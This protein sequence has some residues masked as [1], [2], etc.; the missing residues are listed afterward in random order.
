[1]S[2]GEQGDWFVDADGQWTWRQPDGSCWRQGGDGAWHQLA[3]EGAAPEP[4]APVQEGASSDP[5]PTVGLPGAPL[6]GQGPTVGVPGAP[7]GGQ[8]PTVGLPGAPL[9]GQGPTVGVPGSLLGVPHFGFQQIGAANPPAPDPGGDALASCAPVLPDQA[10]SP[11]HPGPPPVE[12]GETAAH[13]VNVPPPPT[14]PVQSPLSVQT[15][16]P[17]PYS[18][19]AIP[20][21]SGMAQSAVDHHGAM[22]QVAVPLERQ[23]SAMAVWALV[24]GILPPLCYVNNVIAVILGLEARHHVKH[25]HGALRGKTPAILAVVFGI[26]WLATIPIVVSL[27]ISNGKNIYNGLRTS[28]EDSAAKTTLNAAKGAI[29]TIFE[30]NH[31]N[32]ALIPVGSLPQLPLVH[33][34]TSCST[35]TICYAN[36]TG[37]GF[38]YF[39]MCE[40]TG[41]GHA[42]IVSLT[43]GGPAWYG[44]AQGA[45]PA[46]GNPGSDGGQPVEAATWRQGGFPPVTLDVTLFGHRYHWKL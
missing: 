10:S 4:E 35:K 22:A 38:S 7:L 30:S 33:F 25:S 3:L 11:P 36:G 14:A 34:S 46:L 2:S 8:G 41:V 44:E 31:Q 17:S 18:G 1:V 40:E 27:A 9:G 26:L 5:G 42:W 39:Q 37:D 29:N 21:V 20:H 45:C 19:S 32:Y 15:G 24:L 16:D 28:A 43:S 23:T 13:R 12:I 6:G